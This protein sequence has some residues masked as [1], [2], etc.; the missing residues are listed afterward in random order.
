MVLLKARF[1][2]FLKISLKGEDQNR[3]D[4]EFELKKRAMED[5]FNKVLEIAYAVF[6]II[7]I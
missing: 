2:F 6:Q 4:S 1:I 3:V 7:I 5:R